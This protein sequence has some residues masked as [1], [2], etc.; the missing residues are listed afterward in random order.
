MLTQHGHDASH[1][2]DLNLRHASDD[3]IWQWALANTA[4][5][6]TKDEDFPRRALVSRSAPVIVWLRVG[7]SS[8]RALLVWL[9]PLLPQIEAEIARGESII[10]VR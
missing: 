10:E 8:R 4:V 3:T 6:I 9:E 5:V 7:N 2:E 1:V